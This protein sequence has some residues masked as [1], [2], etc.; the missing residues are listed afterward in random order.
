MH[1][2]KKGDNKTFFSDVAPS[3]RTP[4]EPRKTAQRI[5]VA[6][7]FPSEAHPPSV[8]VVCDKALPSSA[9]EPKSI[10]SMGLMFVLYS[11]RREKRI[12]I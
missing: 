11:F 3:L 5:M 9:R 4:S 12:L 10:H 8:F 6:T 1:I 7:T 2:G